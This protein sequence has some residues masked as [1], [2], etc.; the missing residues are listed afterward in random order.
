MTQERK[1]GLELAGNLLTKIL[2]GICIFFLVDL[3]QDIKATHQQLQ[4][5]KAEVV[6]LKYRVNDLTREVRESKQRNE[7]EQ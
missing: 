4:D 5:I 3:V 6:I 2:L 7:Y 1:Q